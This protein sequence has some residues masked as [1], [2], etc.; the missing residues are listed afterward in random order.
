MLLLDSF[1][2][3]VKLERER[4]Y[5]KSTSDQIRSMG[6]ECTSSDNNNEGVPREY[7]KT[8]RVKIKNLTR[9]GPKMVNFVQCSRDINFIRRNIPIPKEV[10]RFM[11]KSEISLIQ[12]IWISTAELLFYHS[13]LILW[14]VSGCV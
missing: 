14:G 10:D 9:S 12:L 13:D 11:M 8:R 5:I 7:P 1:S 4:N 3:N 6:L 2:C